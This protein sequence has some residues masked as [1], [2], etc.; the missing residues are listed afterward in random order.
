MPPAARIGDKHICP[1]SDGPKPHV[2]GV[3]SMG[4]PTVR[5]GNKPA[6]RM[7]DMCVCV[8]PPNSIVKGSSTVQIGGMPAAR[9]GDLTAHGGII[10]LG[11]PTVIIGEVGMGSP[12][13]LTTA[14]RNAAKRGTPL[15]C[16]GPCPEGKYL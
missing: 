14:F 8:G 12:I 7:G 9:M 10:A 6:A 16:R 1:L 4:F 13:S 5:I 15:V 3:V 11:C 2:G